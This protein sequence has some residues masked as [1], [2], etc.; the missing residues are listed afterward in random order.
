MKNI[1]GIEFEDNEEACE[2][3]TKEL[4]NGRGED[5]DDE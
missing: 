5:E 3:T 2:E 1:N 4:T